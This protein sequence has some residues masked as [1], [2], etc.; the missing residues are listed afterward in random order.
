MLIS[1]VSVLVVAQSSSEI[2][3]VLMNNPVYNNLYVLGFLVDCLLTGQ[4][5]V[6]TYQLL[7][8]YSLP[9]DDGLQMYPKYVEVE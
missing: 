6:N 5:T 8:I 7:Y 2:P 4:Q 9:P 3:E 1:A